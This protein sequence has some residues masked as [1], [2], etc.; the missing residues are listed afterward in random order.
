ML[1]D[2]GQEL[3]KLQQLLPQV[4]LREHNT[5]EI[6]WESM[7]YLEFFAKCSDKPA[8]DVYIHMDIGFSLI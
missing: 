6:P 3:Q 8:Y 5:W 2:L 1:D 7:G 4:R